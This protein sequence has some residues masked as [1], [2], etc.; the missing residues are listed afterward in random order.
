[1]IRYLKHKE[2]D[3][4]RWDAAAGQAVNSRVYAN[5]WYLDIVSPGWDALTDEN[6]RSI[7]PLTHRRKAGISYL[8]QPFF[9]QQLGL[10]SGAHLTPELLDEFL[11]AIPEEYR[12]IEI[13][14]NAF[15][16]P[17]PEKYDI[18]VRL[19]H[20]LDL[21]S[22]Y[23]NLAAN[24]SQNTRR[25]IVKAIE[26]GVTIGR[27]AGTDELI[28][29]F[30]ENFGKKEGVLTFGDYVT[31]QKLLDHA[32]RKDMGYITGAY[33][34]EGKLS[35]AAFF[36][37]EKSRVYLLFAASA[38]EARENGA[39]FMLIDH[40]I[41]ENALQQLTLDFEGGNDP[42]IGRFYKSF[43]A[44][45]IPYSLLRINRLSWPVTQCFNLLQMLK[46]RKK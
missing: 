22:P 13:H 23:E 14:L 28:S 20:E 15:N 41:R 34:Q 24:Y 36:L 46:G 42:G 8:Y 40:F 6:Y 18:S 2:I 5:S 43:G 39:M 45:G 17:D 38:P 12:Y 31:L 4:T 7:F 3:R 32:R 27:K 16:K 33:N 9:T 1:M 44:A 21:I 11:A 25:N 35:A 37:K 10:F 19:N 26:S 30:R 29:L